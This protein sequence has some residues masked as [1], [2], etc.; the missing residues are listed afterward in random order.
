M[1]PTSLIHKTGSDSIVLVYKTDHPISKEDYLK[2]R[3]RK[4]RK[5]VSGKAAFLRDIRLHVRLPGSTETKL[6]PIAPDMLTIELLRVLMRRFNLDADK[7]TV[8]YFVGD[9]LRNLMPEM[10]SKTFF[11]LGITHVAIIRTVEEGLFSL[12]ICVLIIDRCN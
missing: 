3:R 8:K 12:L 10:L 2:R 1:E 9:E 4:S 7:H 5:S 6:V 11:V